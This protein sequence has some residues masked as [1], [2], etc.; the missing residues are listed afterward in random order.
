MRGLFRA[1]S[2]HALLP[3]RV[4]ILGL[5]SL[6]LKTVIAKPSTGLLADVQHTGLRI[7]LHCE[8]NAEA[9]AGHEHDISRL[10]QSITVS[11]PLWSWIV[12]HC[13]A[14]KLLWDDDYEE[15]ARA[16]E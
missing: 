9:E 10:R 11:G 5:V 7:R 3:V 14:R 2:D 13:V 8:W 15:R 1:H 4:R 16:A 6:T 12:S